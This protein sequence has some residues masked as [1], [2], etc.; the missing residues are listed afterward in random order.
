MLIL[1]TGGAASGKSEFAE[2]LILRS[3]ARPLVYLAT[4][5]IWDA[6]DRKRVAR[7]RL[8]RKDKGFETV[9][10]SRHLDRVLLPGNSAVLLEC[11][12]NICVN[13]CFGPDGFDGAYQR[14]FRGLTHLQAQCRDLVIVSNELFSDGR[15]YTP[16]S[17]AYKQILAR[18]N[19]DVAAM[20][21]QVWEVCCGIP[22]LWIGAQP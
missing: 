19:R 21:D 6:E 8:L 18:L 4:M 2:S 11:M 15:T 9:E 7:H 22:I 17:E 1:V 16:E 14:I 13:E 3:K 5:E 10:A 20:A 12:S